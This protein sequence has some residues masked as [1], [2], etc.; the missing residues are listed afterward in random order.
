MSAGRA[1]RRLAQYD[2]AVAD[3]NQA[4]TLNPEFAQAYMN[5]GEAY[6]SQNE[7]AKALVDLNRAIELDGIVRRPI[8]IAGKLIAKRVIISTLSLTTRRLLL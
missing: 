7:P 8:S 6:T 1:Y 4:I 2:K 3:F 5:R